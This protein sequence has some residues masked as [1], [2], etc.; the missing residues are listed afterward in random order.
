L[1]RLPNPIAARYMRPTKE[2]DMND[3]HQGQGGGGQRVAESGRSGPN[4]TLIGLAIVAALFVA[5]FLQ[6]SKS[7]EIYFLVFHK[8]TTIRWS[9]LVALVLGIAIDRIFMTWWRRRG[10]RKST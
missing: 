9:L 7:T 6:N 8:T 3:E 5:F 4:I 10:K 1:P 2:D